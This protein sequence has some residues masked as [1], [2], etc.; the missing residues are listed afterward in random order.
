MV[1]EIHCSAYN[2]G[3]WKVSEKWKE[4]DDNKQKFAGLTANFYVLWLKL[5]SAP[6]TPNVTLDVKPAS[7]FRCSYLTFSSPSSHTHTHTHTHANIRWRAM[8]ADRWMFAL[9]FSCLC[10]IFPPLFLS[11]FLSFFC[12][13][14]HSLTI[15][16]SLPRSSP[17]SCLFRQIK[18][19]ILLVI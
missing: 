13:L 8:G 1:L 18:P 16:P 2:T 19:T 12:S 5:F 7:T 4:L 9:C 10:W 11:F 17:L 14:C 6:E 3:K 15:V